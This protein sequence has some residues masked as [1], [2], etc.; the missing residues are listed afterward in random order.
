MTTPFPVLRLPYLV[1]MPILEQMEFMERIALSVLSKRARMFVQL[2]KMKCKHIN[3]RL[4]YN[5]V[6]MNVCFDN[7]EE[8]NVDMY[9]DRYKVD[10]RYEKDHISWWPGSLPPMDYVLPIMDVTHCKSIKK[11][12]FPKVYEYDPAYETTIPLLKKLPKVDE[13]I[14]EDFTSY[15]F[16]PESPLRNVLKIVLPVSS[17]VTISDHVRKPKYIREILTGKFDAVSVQLLGD[18]RFPLNDLRITNAKT[19]KLDRVAF[20]V[21]DLNLYF[22]LW[23][24]KKCNPRLEYL[25]VR[26]EGNVNKNLLLEGLNAV[27]FPIKTKRTFRV[28]G[29]VQQLS[30]G[31]I[32]VFEFDIT[33]ADKRQ[34]TIRIGTHGTVCFYVWPESTTDTTNLVPNQSS[35]MRRFSWISN[36][37][38]SF[39][40]RF[41]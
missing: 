41:K 1:L 25:S 4:E 37:Y 23:M 8:L 11:L 13:V 27:P 6:K 5:T 16:S 39:I 34:A 35:F 28:S 31:E 17:A 38:N 15:I 26:Q 3:L 20:K 33:R 2:L 29:N 7:D 9:T 12:I 14:V 32:I 24:K 19:L 10:L 30:W 22:K 18:W 40:E 21:E 36:F